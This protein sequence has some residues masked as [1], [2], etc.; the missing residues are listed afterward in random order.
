M[1]DR[2]V[3]SRWSFILALALL[4]TAPLIWPSTPPLV[5]L[6]GHVGRY[7]V[8]LDLHSSPSLQQFFEFKW[9]MIGNLGVDLLIIPAA[10][11]FG[12]EP[13]VKLLV[14]LIPPL[15]TIGLLWVAR[16]VHGGVP[17]TALFA[18]PF[19]YGYPFN[20]GFINFALSMALAL[21]AFALWL[22]LASPIKRRLRSAL[23][24]PISCAIWMA[25]AFGWGAL[26]LL[27][28]SSE[29]VSARDSGRRWLLAAAQAAV[30]CLPLA[31]PLLL[32]IVWRGA[33]VAGNTQGFFRPLL[34]VWAILAALRDRWLLW[35][36]L[37]VGV[38][39]V[40]I[41]SALL[42]KHV[43]FSR[44]LAI[45]A[46]A[47]FGVFLVL[48]QRVFG[49]EYADM[50]LVPFLLMLAILAI[51]LREPVAPALNHRL[52]LL[53]GLFLLL[54]LTGN[55]VSF[56]IADADARSRLAALDYVPVGARVLS[57][58]GDTCGG[59]WEMTRY[60]H[61]GSFVIARKQGFSNDQWQLPGA[62]LLRVKYAPAIPFDADASEVTISPECERRIRVRDGWQ[63]PGSRG[64]TR[65]ADAAL[66]RFP[67]KAFDYA[68]LI[69]P[70]GFT[71]KPRPG[72]DL[73]W[74]GRDS[75]LFKVDHH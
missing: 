33:G 44:R 63:N 60:S 68:W 66:D 71:P 38:A 1:A 22:R 26:G 67:H 42:D 74:R 57:L 14:L 39:L 10:K 75:L 69:R 15:T 73:V 64:W 3:W 72:L 43:E 61:F 20:F 59:T 31:F 32:M 50:R 62:Q 55:T 46:L 34:K 65:T 51:R 36:C 47:L 35:D 6:P 70:E 48:P 18:L 21:I 28:W 29:L 27:V 37:G 2:A 49:S 12:L 54:R 45:P 52:A 23:F 13:G 7:R 19:V 25:H 5:D 24:V 41:G 8:E 4:C 40:L 9:A 11:V 30:K 56:A 17:P 16:E 58:I 53:G